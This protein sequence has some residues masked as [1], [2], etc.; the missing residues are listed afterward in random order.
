[1]RSLWLSIFAPN[2][3]THDLLL[4]DNRGSGQSAAIDCPTFQQ[5][6]AR[7]TG[8]KSPNAPLS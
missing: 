4:V 1:M 2:M 6:S 8:T 7:L 5:V 3:D